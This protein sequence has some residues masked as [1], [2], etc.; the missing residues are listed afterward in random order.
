[1]RYLIKQEIRMPFTFAEVV[2]WLVVGGLGGT[3]A[4]MVVKR[5]R[6]GFG[7]IV[8]VALGCL[9]AIIGGAVFNYV[10]ILPGLQAISVSLRDL[11]S[12]FL[13]SLLLLAVVWVWQRYRG[14]NGARG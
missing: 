14:P 12:A 2:T 13:G 4:G 5:R 3:A 11:L 10:K 1:M 9:G 7:V 6:K 8:N